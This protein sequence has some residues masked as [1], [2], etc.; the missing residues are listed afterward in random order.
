M[1]GASDTEPR[2]R[3]T[4]ILRHPTISTSSQHLPRTSS[5]MPSRRTTPPRRCRTEF[6][7]RELSAQQRGLLSWD[8]ETA[9]AQ[10]SVESGYIRIDGV[11]LATRTR[12]ARA[13]FARIFRKVGTGLGVRR[14]TG[15]QVPAAEGPDGLESRQRTGGLPSL[16]VRLETRPVFAW[17]ADWNGRSW[18]RGA[19]EARGVNIMRACLSPHLYYIQLRPSRPPPS[20]P[21]RDDCYAAARGGTELKPDTRPDAKSDD[22]C[23]LL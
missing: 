3:G 8:L 17:L 2:P 10:R 23:H 12:R 18:P 7:P 14:V 16:L 22:R 9:G 21:F 20:C 6:I 19:A 13:C 11:A 1:S 5:S 15:V 4:P